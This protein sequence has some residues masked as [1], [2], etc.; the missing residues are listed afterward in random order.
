MATTFAAGA[1]R[2]RPA[3]GGLWTKGRFGAAVED[4]RL[5]VGVDYS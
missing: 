2:S 5:R 3:A 4:W 1:D